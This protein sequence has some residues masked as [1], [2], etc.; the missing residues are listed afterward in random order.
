MNVP[1]MVPVE[2]VRS[3]GKVVTSVEWLSL[4]D[5]TPGLQGGEVAVSMLRSSEESLKSV[6]CSNFVTMISG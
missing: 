3:R 1:K 5:V 4:G 2:Q 6:L